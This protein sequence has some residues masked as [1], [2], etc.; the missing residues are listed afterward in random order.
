M[1]ANDDGILVPSRLTLITGGARSGKSALAQKIGEAWRG[2]VCFVATATAGDEDM[3][4]RIARHRRERPASWTTME[5]PVEVASDIRGV[6]EGS[7]VIIDCVTMWVSNLLLQGY[8]AEKVEEAAATLSEFLGQRESPSVV[9]TN[10]VGLGIVPDNEL[11]RRYRDTLGRVN[12]L[13]ARQAGVTLFASMG[14]VTKLKN[15]EDLL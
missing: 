14:Q 2:Q 15:I 8:E 4:D 6:A 5:S 3:A 10:E 12:Q 13:I 11:A 7:L 9:V 1:N